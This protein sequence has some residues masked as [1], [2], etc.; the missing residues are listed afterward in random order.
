PADFVLPR[1]RRGW[2]PRRRLRDPAGADP[3]PGL[4][5]A[6]RRA[7]GVSCPPSRH[8]LHG[9]ELVPPSR[10]SALGLRPAD[11]ARRGRWGDALA[12]SALDRGARRAPG[13]E[14][15]RGTRG[16][17]LRPGRARGPAARAHPR[18]DAARPAVPPTG[19]APLSHGVLR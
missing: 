17:H 18:N 19:E 6:A 11:A 13:A 8:A 1:D 7:R 16:R 2:G 14:L 3:L 5:R 9:P 15:L 4:L 12:A 10:A